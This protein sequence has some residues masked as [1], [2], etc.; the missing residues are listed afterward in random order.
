[1]SV[2]HNLAMDY[3]KHF[4]YFIENECRSLVTDLVRLVQMVVLKEVEKHATEKTVM[5]KQDQDRYNEAINNVVFLI[6]SF[7]AYVANN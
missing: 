1:V 2:A 4:F 5:L 7:H 3:K 6:F